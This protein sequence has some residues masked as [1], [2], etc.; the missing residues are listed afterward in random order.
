VILAWMDAGCP[1]VDLPSVIRSTLVTTTAA[2]MRRGD[3]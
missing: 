3:A 2:L 1:D